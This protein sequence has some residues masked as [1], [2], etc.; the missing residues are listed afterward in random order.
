MQTVKMQMGNFS[1]GMSEVQMFQLNQSH[2]MMSQ[3]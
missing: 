1:I 3:M 2:M